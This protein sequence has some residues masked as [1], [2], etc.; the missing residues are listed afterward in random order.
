MDS[1]KKLTKPETIAL[2]LVISQLLFKVSMELIK[3]HELRQGNSLIDSLFWAGTIAWAV[4]IPLLIQRY[5]FVY[6]LAA[7]LGILNGAVGLLF[8]LMQ[9]CRHYIVG[10]TI[11]V[12]GLLIAYFSFRAYRELSLNQ[13]DAKER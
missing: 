5:R 13:R 11:F 4:I 3:S 6:L 7:I 9:V 8:P 1:N 12:H 10:P 2:V